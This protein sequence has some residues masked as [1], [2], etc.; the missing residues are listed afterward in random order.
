M[1]PLARSILQLPLDLLRQTLPQLH[2][3][4]IKRI[5]IPNRTLGERQMLIIH[6]QGS[7]RR[8]RDLIR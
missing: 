7:Q 4:L 6:N 8:R 1:L 5:D 3:P 2:T